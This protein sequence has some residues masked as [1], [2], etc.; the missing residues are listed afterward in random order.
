VAVIEGDF[1]EGMTARCAWCRRIEQVA[2]GEMIAA[3]RPG[4]G[5]MRLFKCSDCQEREREGAA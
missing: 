1:P 3:R 2:E 4:S 5:A